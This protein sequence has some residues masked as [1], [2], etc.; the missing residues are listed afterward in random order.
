[1]ND[2]FRLDMLRLVDGTFRVLLFMAFRDGSLS[3]RRCLCDR[4]VLRSRLVMDLGL[5]SGC[6]RFLNRHGF[7][8]LALDFTDCSL[9]L[10]EL[11]LQHSFRRTRLH[12]L[13]LPL[14]SAARTL[15]DLHPHL[16]R[17]FRQAVDCPPNNCN[18]IRHQYFLK[19]SGSLP[20][21][22]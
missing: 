3:N 2:L 12:V 10:F 15:V 13:E 4:L 14:H 8:V 7:R 6:D 1:M 9:E 20:N 16:G 18:K 11:A 17:I 21:S 19:K 5:R 22:P